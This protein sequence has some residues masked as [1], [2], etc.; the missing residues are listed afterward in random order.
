VHFCRNL[1]A[2]C[3]RAAEEADF[4][5]T[6]SKKNTIYLIAAHGSRCRF[7]ANDKFDLMIEAL[8]LCGLKIGGGSS[9]KSYDARRRRLFAFL[10]FAPAVLHFSKRFLRPKCP[11]RE[12][13]SS[14]KSRRGGTFNFYVTRSD[15]P[16]H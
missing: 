2:Q 12:G 6:Q 11:F 9:P 10:H 15:V 1:L 5:Q 14:N 16:R 7:F 13:K 8:F 3:S 4:S